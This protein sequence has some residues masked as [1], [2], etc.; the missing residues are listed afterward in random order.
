MFGVK[1]KVGLEGIWA[2]VLSTLTRIKRPQVV[3]LTQTLI[4]PKEVFFLDFYVFVFFFKAFYTIKNLTKSTSTPSSPA[5][6]PNFIR[7]RIGG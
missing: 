6:V 5:T 3:S 7:F 1:G 2:C 4:H